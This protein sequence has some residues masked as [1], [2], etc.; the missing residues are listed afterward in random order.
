MRATR[1]TK[2][3]TICQVCGAEGVNNRYCRSCAVEVSRETMAQAALIGHAT[4]KSPNVKA[5]I[6]KTISDHAVANS[7][8]SASSLPGWLNEK[9]YEQDILPRLRTIKVQEIAQALHISQPYAAPICAGRR[10]AHPRH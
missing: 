7:W 8:W 3:L 4:P 1:V 5:C 10:W 2:Q 6:S 9:C